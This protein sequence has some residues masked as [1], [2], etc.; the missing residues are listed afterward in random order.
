MYFTVYILLYNKSLTFSTGWIIIWKRASRPEGEAFVTCAFAWST[1][2]DLFRK[3]SRE[4]YTAFTCISMFEATNYS[5][6]KSEFAHGNYTMKS[7][8]FILHIFWSI[9]CL[10]SSQA[11]LQ[12]LLH[13]FLCSS[14]PFMDLHY[15]A[16]QSKQSACAALAD[17]SY[18]VSG[19][20][21][22]HFKI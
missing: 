21:V 6:L 5:S 9:Y 7:L 12:H 19:I 11:Q 2:T 4:D 17:H 10:V 15:L 16:L 18:T 8:L 3:I 1:C 14:N 22:S 13:H 20:C